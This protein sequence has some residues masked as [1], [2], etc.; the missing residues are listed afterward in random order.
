MGIIDQYCQAQ[1]I[2]RNELTTKRAPCRG[3]IE[4]MRMYRDEVMYLLRLEGLSY[5]RIAVLMGLKDHTSGMAAVRRHCAL[6]GLYIPENRNSVHWSD[7][8]D[9]IVWDNIN[10]PCPDFAHL[11]PRRSLAA[12]TCRRAILRDGWMFPSIKRVA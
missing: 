2:D 12:V 10:T 1:G 3:R 6:K 8:E 5:P 4:P 9:Q 7:E 11:L